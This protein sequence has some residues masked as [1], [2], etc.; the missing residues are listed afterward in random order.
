MIIVF[1]TEPLIVRRKW[2]IGFSI[3]SLNFFIF[4]FYRLRGITE[5]VY[6]NEGNHI[7]GGAANMRANCICIVEER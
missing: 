7:A 5:I 2:K 3:F 4:I 1:R 6:W